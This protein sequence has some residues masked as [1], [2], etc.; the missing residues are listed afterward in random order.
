MLEARCERRQ[1][2]LASGRAVRFAGGS[3]FGTRVACR[4]NPLGVKRGSWLGK[5]REWLLERIAETP[6][7]TLEEIRSE[8]AGRGIWVG[9]ATVW[10]SFAGEGVR[11]KKTV[12]A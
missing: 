8:P 9:Y 12:H 5:K 4:R 2:G 7:L 10:R 1:R 6:D 3:S 11:S